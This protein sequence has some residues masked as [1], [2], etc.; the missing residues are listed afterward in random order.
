MSEKRTV[1]IDAE[2]LAGR[3]FPY[4]HDMALVEDLDLLEATPGKDLNWLEGIEL[5]EEDN[6]PAVFDRYSNSFLKIYFE[7]PEG[8]ENEIAR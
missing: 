1:A 8:R 4:Q 2:V 3:S 7:I 6:T 5:L